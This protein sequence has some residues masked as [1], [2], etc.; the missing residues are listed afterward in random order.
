MGLRIG[1][2][3]FPARGTRPSAYRENCYSRIRHD[4]KNLKPDILV[5]NAEREIM[6]ELK[7][8]GRN[9]LIT[10]A[11]KG[12]GFAAATNFLRGGANVVIVVGARMFLKKPNNRFRAKAPAR[13]LPFP[14][15]LVRR[16]IVPEFSG[17]LKTSSV[18]LTFW[19]TM[20]E[21][22]P[23]AR[24]KRRLTSAGKPTST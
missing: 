17:V 19:S 3:R 16:M 18:R 6:V 12:I 10:G 2:R 14:G 22:I 11:S 13:S 4:P 8:N 21:R 23:I 5:L 20:P 15:T 1:P 24:S 9:A 7:M